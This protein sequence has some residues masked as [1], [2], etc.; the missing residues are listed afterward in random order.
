[1]STTKIAAQHLERLAVVYVRQSTPGQLRNHPESTAR[2]YA[3][4]ERAREFGWPENRIR[5]IDAD[6]GHSAGEHAKGART[7]FDE[8]CRLPTRWR[9]KGVGSQRSSRPR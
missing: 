9:R 4:A 2:Q 8:L 6:L 7:G 1:M 3:L 5:T